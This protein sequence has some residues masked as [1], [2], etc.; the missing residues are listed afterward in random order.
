VAMLMELSTADLRVAEAVMTATQMSDP[1][2]LYSDELRAKAR[3]WQEEGRT[4]PFSDPAK[5]PTLKDF[6][7]SSR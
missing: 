7:A 1:A 4:P 6:S 2:M 5:A 3:L